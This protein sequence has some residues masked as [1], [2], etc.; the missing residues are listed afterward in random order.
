MLLSE[1]LMS[2]DK[3]TFTEAIASAHREGL[4]ANSDS[5]ILGLGVNYANGADGTTKGLAA[6]FGDRVMDVIYGY[7]CWHGQ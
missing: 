2:G 5:L 7:G 1:I 3:Y 6:E 4:I